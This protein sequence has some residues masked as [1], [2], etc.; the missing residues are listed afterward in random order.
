MIPATLFK[1]A[2]VPVLALAMQGAHAIELGDARGG[3]IEGLAPRR[4]GDA[5]CRCARMDVSG[6]ELS[7]LL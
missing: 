6:M 4:A 2:A 7:A 5:A 1:W 3:E